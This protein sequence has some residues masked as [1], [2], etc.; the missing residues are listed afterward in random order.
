[1][2]SR[3][4]TAESTLEGSIKSLWGVYTSQQAALEALGNNTQFR[5]S[6]KQPQLVEEGVPHDLRSYVPELAAQGPFSVALLQVEPVGRFQVVVEP[7]TCKMLVTVHGRLPQEIFSN[8]YSS[9][10]GTVSLKSTVLLVPVEGDSPTVSWNAE[11]LGGCDPAESLRGR[12]SVRI[13][14]KVLGVH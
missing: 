9:L 5:W 2:D 10:G 8:E 12:D 11:V 13:V 7:G 14:V 6:T 3:L 4:A 1:M